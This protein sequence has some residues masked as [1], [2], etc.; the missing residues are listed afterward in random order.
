MSDCSDFEAH[1]EAGLTAG[2][3]TIELADVAPI[4]VSKDASVEFT[5][6]L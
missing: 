1:W 6:F 5:D 3:H 4:V 2:L